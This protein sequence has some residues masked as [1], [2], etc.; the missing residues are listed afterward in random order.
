M[1]R[2]EFKKL[3]ME[4]IGQQK[5]EDGVLFDSDN[6]DYFE[7]AQYYYDECNAEAT[8]PL[9]DFLDELYKQLDD[10]IGLGED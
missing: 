5:F 8:M 2:E 9:E 7:I 6:I 10:I 4:V 1:T 3:V